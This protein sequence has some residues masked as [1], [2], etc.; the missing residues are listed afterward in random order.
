MSVLA[1]DPGGTTGWATFGGEYRIANDGHGINM[2]QMGPHTHYQQLAAFIE[3]LHAPSFT[4]VCESFEYRRG[5]RDNVE[6]ISREYIG[7]VNL[8]A[9][10]RDIPVHWQ[11]AAKGKAFFKDEKIKYLGL[12]WPGHKHA[13]DALRHLLHY[14]MF[15]KH[16]QELALKLKGL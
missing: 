9:A 6:L 11:T 4:I 13:M 16:D 12:W 7:I 2:G 8:I 1:L 15:E 14:Q 5:L 10:E 3:R